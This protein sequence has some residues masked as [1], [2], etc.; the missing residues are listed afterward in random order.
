L[1]YDCNVTKETISRV[2]TTLIP[3]LIGVGTDR[4]KK[5][6]FTGTN[7]LTGKVDNIFI[8]LLSAVMPGWDGWLCPVTLLLGDQIKGWLRAAASKT[9]R[10]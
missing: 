10:R 5:F 1:F 9:W 7:F 6:F 3:E 2:K 8:E 4:E